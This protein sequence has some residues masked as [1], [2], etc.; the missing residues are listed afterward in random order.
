MAVPEL[1]WL[2]GRI[3]QS[4]ATKKEESR[5][6]EAMGGRRVPGSGALPQSRW[7]QSFARAGIVPLTDDHQALSPVVDKR[8]RSSMGADITTETHSVEHKRTKHKSISLK[9]EW[10][11]KI[12]EVA[13]LEQRSPMLV[14]TFESTGEDWVV[15]PLADYLKVQEKAD[16]K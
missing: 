13:Y 3:K 5:V 15:M 1:K 16:G 9:Q 2:N 8:A 4:R 12:K 10:L 14:L 11:D 7:A 6:A